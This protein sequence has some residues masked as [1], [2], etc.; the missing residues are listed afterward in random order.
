MNERRIF[1]HPIRKQTTLEFYP[2]EISI[3]EF[4]EIIVDNFDAYSKNAK[5]GEFDK[6][7]HIEEW[8]EQYLGWLDI[9][10]ER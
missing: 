8:V 1:N 9:E 10:E 4:K 3:Q 5:T 2:N 6:P 7:K